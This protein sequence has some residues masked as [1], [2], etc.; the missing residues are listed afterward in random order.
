MLSVTLIYQYDIEIRIH[1]TYIKV[2]LN[3][4]LRKNKNVVYILTYNK[5]KNMHLTNLN[6]FIN[7]FKCQVSQHCAI[8]YLHII[9]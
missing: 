4:I 7:L 9:N 8:S 2:S 5:I 1:I 3:I 6:L